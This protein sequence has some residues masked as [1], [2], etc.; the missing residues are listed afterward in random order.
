MFP[1]QVTASLTNASLQVPVNK[2]QS[3]RTITILP[4]ESSLTIPLNVALAR[5]ESMRRI[6]R[7][8]EREP[9]V[10]RQRG[11]SAIQTTD[12]RWSAN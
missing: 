2:S 7:I 4:G 9:S 3:L 10:P 11:D 1:T 8:S 12:L 6:V 5:T